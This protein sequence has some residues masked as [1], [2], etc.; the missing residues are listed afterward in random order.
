MCWHFHRLS[1]Y[2]VTYRRWITSLRQD[3]KYCTY[4]KCQSCVKSLLVFAADESLKQCSCSL[5]GHFPSFLSFLKIWM[6]TSVEHMR[7][8]SVWNPFS[9]VSRSTASSR[10]CCRGIRLSAHHFWNLQFPHLQVSL[11][12]SHWHFLS[13]LLLA[14]TAEVLRWFFFF[15]LRTETE[16]KER[17]FWNRIYGSCSYRCRCGIDMIVAAATAQQVTAL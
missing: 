3:V 9:P 10:H 15:L 11:I 12:S 8:N 13:A 4:H 16:S 2:S 6:W 17:H 5:G 7:D 1:S 14:Q